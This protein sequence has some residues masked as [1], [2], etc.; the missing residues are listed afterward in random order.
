MTDAK[1]HNQVALS[2]FPKRRGVSVTNEIVGPLSP[3]CRGGL[4]LSTDRRYRS[5]LLLF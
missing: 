2:F 5:T 1:Q 4:K 3:H